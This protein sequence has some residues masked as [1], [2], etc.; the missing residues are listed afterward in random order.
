MF[1]TSN[2]RFSSFL[3]YNICFTLQAMDF[4]LI[5]EEK[6]P[7]KRSL[8]CSS[9]CSHKY[10]ITPTKCS[11]QNDET[12]LET[13]II[14]VPTNRFTDIYS[15][16]QYP[17]SRWNWIVSNFLQHSSHCPQIK[18]KINENKVIQILIYQIHW[19]TLV[20]TLV[21]QIATLLNH[22]VLYDKKL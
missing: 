22:N 9:I 13:E 12:K 10:M 17:K 1:N 21:S 6:S 11:L 16:N 20:C 7:K 19:N 15:L 3:G 2:V 14:I 4:R 8:Q 5:S 18:V